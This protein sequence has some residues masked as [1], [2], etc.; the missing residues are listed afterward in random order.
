MRNTI[1]PSTTTSLRTHFLAFG[2]VTTSPVL[3][4]TIDT[5]YP[6]ESGHFRIC[7]FQKPARRFR[8]R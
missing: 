5:P 1:V 6:H 2:L 4:G 8:A 7:Q 3:I